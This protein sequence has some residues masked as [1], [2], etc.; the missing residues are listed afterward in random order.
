MTTCLDSPVTDNDILNLK[1]SQINKNTSKNTKWASSLY[2]N[3]RKSRPDQI[4]EL[5]TINKPMMA[6]WLTRFV[7]EVRNAKGDEYL[8]KTLYQ[9][10]CGLWR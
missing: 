9:I 10:V 7:M 8:P 5:Q 2:E 4:Q 3:W 1:L 6:F